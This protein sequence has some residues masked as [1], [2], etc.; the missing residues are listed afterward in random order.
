MILKRFFDESLA[1]ASFLL[2]DTETHEAIVLDPNRDVDAYLQAAAA[3]Q[4]RIVAVTETHIHA[5]YLSGTRELAQRAGARAYLSDEGDADWK[6]AWAGE[7]NVTLVR[8]GGTIRAGGIRL[9]VLATPGHTPEHLSFRLTDETASREPL[10]VFT[11]DFVFVGDVGRPDLLERAA[12]QVGTMETG[13]RTLHASLARFR[14]RHADHLM[15]WPG[16]G[17]GSACGKSLGGLPVT[18]LAYEKLTNWGVRC[19]NEDEFVREV[20]A[21][22]PEPPAY[23]K[24]MKH[25]NKL[26]PA[27]LGGFREPPR[28]DGAGIVA[29]LERGDTVVDVRPTK[30]VLAGAIPGVIG[31]PVGGSF[32]TWAGGLLP[33]D[34]PLTLLATDP[35]R[36]LAAVRQLALVG[37]DRVKGW[38]GPDALAAWAREKAALAVTPVIAPDQ[39]F[40][41]ARRGEV[42]LLDVRGA[43][44]YAAGHVPGARHVPLG[45]LPERARELP[46]D[47][48]LALYCSGGTRSRIGV[49][50]LRRAGFTEL[51]DLGGGF[52]AH[53][54]A[55]LPVE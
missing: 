30:D 51:M 18:T 6:Y 39:A 26:G 11:G 42:V 19:A 46:R 9:D 32:T 55:G 22:Q 48:P 37:L 29:A 52:G 21:G 1:Q 54:E 35:A 25:L 14:E 10:G 49:S 45:D 15:L 31:I 5:D 13:A 16:H 12:N 28:L 3:E 7:P 8:D 47:R 17:A 4:L 50:L 24:H 44:E 43:A 53:R 27:I 2:G 36:V 40:E 41:R 34:R 20:L 38:F 33:Y 23:F